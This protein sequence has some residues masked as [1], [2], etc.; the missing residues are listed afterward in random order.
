MQIKAFPLMKS[1]P[2]KTNN[3]PGENHNTTFQTPFNIVK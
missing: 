2:D 1:S 3:D